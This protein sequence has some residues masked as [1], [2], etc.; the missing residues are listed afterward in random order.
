MK[1]AALNGSQLK[2]AALA[3]MTIDHVVSVVFPGYPTVWWI[4]LLHL[5]GR[6]AAP[7]FWFFVAEGYHYT[8]DRR[9]YAARLLVF[10]VIGHFAYNFAFGIPFLPFQTSVLIRPACFGPCFGVLQRWASRRARACLSGRKRCSF[11]ASVR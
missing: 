8:H 3:A 4:V 11:W 9:K 5:I 1:Q 7:I 10:A 6:L 2:A